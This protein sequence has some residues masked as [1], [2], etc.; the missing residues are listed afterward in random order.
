MSNTEKPFWETTPLEKMSRE[1]WE[2]LCDGC[3]LCCIHRLEDEDS[4]ETVMTNVV[5]RY[6]DL[7][8]CKCTDYANRK[9]NVPDCETITP[10]NI[11][12]LTWLPDTCGYRMV[13]N[14]QGLGWWHPLV[15]GSD[16]SV[17]EAGVSERGFLVSEEEVEDLED[18]VVNW[19]EEQYE[20]AQKE[21]ID[22]KE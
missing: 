17:H 19:L 18:H 8:T 20:I 22:G 21:D 6:L 2:S 5:C 14:G 15:S 9:K 11:G 1:Q 16:E 4:G 7:D 13:Y 12:S 3:G 10:E